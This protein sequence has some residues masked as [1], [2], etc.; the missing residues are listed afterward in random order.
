M[1]TAVATMCISSVSSDGAMTTMLGKEA[2]YVISNAPQC[3]G[4]SAPTKP[5]L[6]TANRTASFINDSTKHSVYESVE[7]F[8][9]NCWPDGGSNLTTPE[10]H[11]EIQHCSWP[12]MLALRSLLHLRSPKSHTLTQNMTVEFGDVLWLL[13]EF[14]L[15]VTT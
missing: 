8:C 9:L 6:S 5:A 2:M 12:H 10:I 7:D 1:D 3:V 4:P 14:Y 15:C 13:L 11:Q